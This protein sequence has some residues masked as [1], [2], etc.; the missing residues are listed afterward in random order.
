MINLK[1]VTPRG[2]MWD[3]GVAS[4]NLKTTTGEITILPNHIP[5]VSTLEKGMVKIVSKGKKM[6]SEILGGVLEVKKG[7]QVVI[8]STEASKFLE[9][10]RLE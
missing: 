4:V 1:V 6:R 8:I 2:L 10:D 5:L 3:D 7:S 9:E